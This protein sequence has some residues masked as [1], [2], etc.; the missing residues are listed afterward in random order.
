M[1]WPNNYAKTDCHRTIGPPGSEMELVHRQCHT[2]ILFSRCRVLK[3]KDLVDLKVLI[4]IFKIFNSM[5]IPNKFQCLFDNSHRLRSSRSQCQYVR[6]CIRTN[7]KA[8]CLSTYG[9][10]CWNSLPVNI[11]KMPTVHEFTQKLKINMTKS[12]N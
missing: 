9:V 3:F 12:Y 10:K 8:H 4:V 5:S 6:N 1:H 11:V 2:Y 7:T